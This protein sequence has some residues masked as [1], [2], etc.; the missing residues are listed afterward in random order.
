MRLCLDGRRLN[1]ILLEDWECPEPAEILFQRFKGTKI[2]SSSAMTSS[3]WQVPLHSD[4][5][6]HTAFQY[7]GQTYEFNVVH[8]GFKTGTA[9]LVRGHD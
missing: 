7:R 8:F 6:Q 1:E 9:A 3:F 4:S 5:K 2:M